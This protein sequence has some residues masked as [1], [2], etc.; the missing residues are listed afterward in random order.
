ME[1]ILAV[2]LPEPWASLSE[3]VR[4]RRAGIARRVDVAVA[5]EAAAC[6][7]ANAGREGNPS[8]VCL[9]AFRSERHIRANGTAQPH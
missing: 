3:A 5:V 1:R 2:Y 7:E 6:S 8:G 9:L 4:A